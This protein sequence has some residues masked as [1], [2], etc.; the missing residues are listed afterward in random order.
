M[1]EW[2]EDM[3][4]SL[5]RSLFVNFLCH[6][7]SLFGRDFPLLFLSKAMCG[8]GVHFVEDILESLVVAVRVPA[9]DHLYGTVRLL[10]HI[11]PNA[12]MREKKT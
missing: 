7:Y 10:F 2:P 4:S 12:A 9:E 3:R 11:C 8:L 1:Q 6:N 5:F